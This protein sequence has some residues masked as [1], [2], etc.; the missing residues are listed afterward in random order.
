MFFGLT[1]YTYADAS[2]QR[3]AID[4][5]IVGARAIAV[6]KD[7][8]QVV[9]AGFKDGLYKTSDAGKS[10]R[11]VAPGLITK[12]N[13]L[14]LDK[15]D[16]GIVYCATDDGLFKS[17]DAGE[18]WQKIFL[19]KDVLERSVRTIAS[20]DAA[21][22]TIFIGT[23]NGVFFS[24][25]NRIIWQKI[26]GEL[27]YAAVL[28]IAVHPDN[29]DS[30]L[31]AS[32]KGLFKSENRMASYEKVLSSFNLESEDASSDVDSAEEE[33]APEEYYLRY[34]TFKS[35]GS[36]T[37][38]AGTKEGL[39]VSLD[40]GKTWRRQIVSGLSEEKI[41]YIL[42]NDKTGILFL[43]TQNGVFA[44]SKDSCQQLYQG[45]DFKICNQ[46]A[47]DSQ[48]NVFLAADKGLFRIDAK[49]IIKEPKEMRRASFAHEPTIHQVQKEAIKYAEVY[50][51]KISQWRKQARLKAFFPEFD[52]SYDKTVFTS[53]SFPQGRGF[54]GPLDWGLTLK[55]DLASLIF[56]TEQTSIDVRSRLMVQLRDDILNEVTRLYF[57]RRRLQLEL[58]E[59]ED[60][61]KKARAEKELRLEE[62]TALIDGLTGGYMSRSINQ[63]G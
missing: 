49:A 42:V 38:H 11:V 32:S 21:P 61:N 50:P 58:A 6:D 8:P 46:L 53:T 36:D 48:S 43:S 51:E 63:E 5:N 2:W 15:Q 27:S 47:Q 39:L 3:I 60:L 17:Q 9:Y 1:R 35:R 56:S 24:P 28:S 16:S 14:Y 13:Y 26:G 34:V 45:A 29:P 33:S 4:A 40:A 44:C 59:A 57:E 30:L 20:C 23:G 55:W 31:V 25:A 22:K 19:G 54:V 18:R 7:N 41:N 12:I 52:L 37:V 10:W 62:L